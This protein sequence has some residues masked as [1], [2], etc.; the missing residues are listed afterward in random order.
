ML[1]RDVVLLVHIPLQR[2]EDVA[3]LHEVLT[4]LALDG[5]QALVR[6][7]VRVG[8]G[9]G[10]RLGRDGEV[11]QLLAQH[12]DSLLGQERVLRGCGV[13]AVGGA[14]GRAGRGGRSVEEVLLEGE[15][16][17]G[18][19]GAVERLRGGAEEG[20]HVLEAI[21]VELWTLLAS[22]TIEILQRAGS[23]C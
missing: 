16:T 22:N 8:R 23:G 13:E 14:V 5:E 6:D 10:P 18:G 11:L 7:A 21:G 9:V 4:A 17:R 2:R 1:L 20:E 12:D 15:Q 19:R 3:L